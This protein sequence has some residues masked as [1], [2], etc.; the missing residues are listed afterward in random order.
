MG[1]CLDS[2]TLLVEQMTQRRTGNLTESGH[3]ASAVECAES[4]QLGKLSGEGGN[5]TGEHRER[6]CPH[7]SEV[8]VCVDISDVIR[9]KR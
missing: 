9:R 3:E 8:Q 4:E 1:P 2:S 5:L 7:Q 6:N